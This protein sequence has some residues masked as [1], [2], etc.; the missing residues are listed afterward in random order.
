MSK[1]TPYNNLNIDWN[2]SPEQAVTLY[3]EWGN[4]D[5]HAEH[6]PVRSK[7]DVAH[8]FVVDNWGEKPVVRLVRRNSE[9]AED[10]VTLE[11]PAEILPALQ[12]ELAGL[13]GISMPSEEIKAWLKKELYGE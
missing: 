5:W 3:L 10:L 11:V 2:L 1:L 4:N 9:Q 13:R 7:D 8:Y 12:K 6:P